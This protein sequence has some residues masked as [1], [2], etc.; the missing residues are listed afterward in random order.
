MT[1][2]ARKYDPD[3]V[4]PEA[5]YEA[6]EAVRAPVEALRVAVK[7]S[8]LDRK[9]PKVRDAIMR[10]SKA[11]LTSALKLLATRRA[12]TAPAGQDAASGPSDGPNPRDDPTAA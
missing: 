1:T 6:A 4:I 11:L 10:S 12:T 9:E 7:S 3:A 8:Y 5:V 2:P